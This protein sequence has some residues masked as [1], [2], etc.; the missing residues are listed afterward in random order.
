MASITE[1]KAD[2]AKLVER[3]GNVTH[4]LR[5]LTANNPGLPE[6]LGA[7]SAEIRAVAVELKRK[8]NEPLEQKR[9][10]R[11]H[12]PP[13]RARGNCRLDDVMDQTS[14]FRLVWT[15]G[16]AGLYRLKHLI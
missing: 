4:V 9:P 2:L 10:A 6:E 1:P 5:S 13:A 11:L 7:L 14:V 8:W 15:K 3:L 12:L 16:R